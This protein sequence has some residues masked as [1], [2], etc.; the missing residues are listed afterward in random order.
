M[1]RGHE[2]EAEVD[3]R[4]KIV[5]KTILD[6]YTNRK[7]LIQFITETY[8]WK[9]GERQIDNY[10]KSA[11]EILSVIS[12]NELEFE[13]SVALNRLDALYTMNYKM[14]D[15]R[16]CRNLI[17]TRAKILGYSAPE[18]IKIELNDSKPKEEFLSKIAK[19]KKD[20]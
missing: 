1:A 5:A 13:K 19:V 17:E 12:E 4:I 20:E 16:E 11:K 8:D 14:H 18:N 3:E 6:G 2:I 10:I 15:F 9:V 7:I